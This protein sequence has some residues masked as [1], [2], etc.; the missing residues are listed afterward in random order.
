MQ[1]ENSGRRP[2]GRRPGNALSRC[3]SSRPAASTTG[4]PEMRR[5]SS[6]RAASFSDAP[7]RTVATSI[8]IASLTFI[9]PPSSSTASV[10]ETGEQ[11]IVK[12]ADDR[13]GIPTSAATADSSSQRIP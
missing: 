4:N 3:A 12:S 6:V 13:F 8:V 9:A 10:G 11:N 2:V 5:S 1:R 7:G